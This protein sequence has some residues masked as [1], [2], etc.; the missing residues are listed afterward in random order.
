M[1]F[2]AAADDLVEWIALRL[3]LGPVPLAASMYGMATAR[4]LAVA[5]R[6]GV[7]ARLARAPASARDVA[8]AYCL[9]TPLRK[10]IEAHDPTAL[11]AAVDAA[12]RAI[13][14]RLGDGAIDGRIQAHVVA[15]ER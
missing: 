2:V 10:E 11:D 9:G 15:V 1:R 13:A 12:T 14:A 8:I 3:N 6:V 4:T 5:Q 7:L